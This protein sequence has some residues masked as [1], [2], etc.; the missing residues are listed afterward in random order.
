MRIKLLVSAVFTALAIGVFLI[1]GKNLIS[2]WLNDTDKVSDMAITLSEGYKYLKIIVIGFIPIMFMQSYADTL[3][4]TGE[5]VLPM[6]ASAGNEGR[7]TKAM[8]YMLYAEAVMYQCDSD[9]YDE[10]LGYMKEIISS[11]E[12]DLVDDYASLWLTSGEWSKESI[13]EINYFSNGGARSWGSPLTSGGTV[14]PML[15]GIPGAT[16]ASGYSDGWGFGPVAKSAW[17]MYEDGDTRREGGIIE[18]DAEFDPIPAEKR[19]WQWTGYYLRKYVGK[20]D[21]NAGQIADADMNH[22]NNLRIY[23]Y[24]ETLLNAAELSVL[25][26][27]DGSSYL[28]EVRAR[29]NCSETGTTQLDILEERHKEFVGEGKRYWDLIRTGQAEAVL[30]AANHEWR[31]NDWTPNKKYW[32]IPQSEIDKDP[33]LKQNNY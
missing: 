30:K 9:R 16:E 19:R 11:G 12:Y 13:W 1:F 5:T 18:Y 28:A 20:R 7:V 10:D 32:P 6:K 2:L 26:G 8:A 4:S 33:A 24:A 14:Y 21:G 31:K 3:R 23:R 22:G 15:I 17:D 25:T 27:A 29:A